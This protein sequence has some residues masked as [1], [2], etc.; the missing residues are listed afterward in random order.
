[1]PGVT[2]TIRQTVYMDVRR[3]AAV[4]YWARTGPKFGAAERGYG[5]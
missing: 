4:G 3:K 5:I 1:M 2:S